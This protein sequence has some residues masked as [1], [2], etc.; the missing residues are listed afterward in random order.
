MTRSQRLRACKKGRTWAWIASRLGIS[1]RAM[2]YLAK[3]YYDEIG[4]R[5][6]RL[7]VTTELASASAYAS[8]ET[9][10]PA[11]QSPRRGTQR[12]RKPLPRF[13]FLSS[14]AQEADGNRLIASSLRVRCLNADG[15]ILAGFSVQRLA[16]AFAKDAHL[17]AIDGLTGG[18]LY[19]PKPRRVRRAA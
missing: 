16:E 10:F 4:E 9:S 5:I 6:D 13:D 19:Q 2:S 3:Y 1:Q 8:S 15:E 14:A 17:T 11:Q 18:V 12:E 7:P